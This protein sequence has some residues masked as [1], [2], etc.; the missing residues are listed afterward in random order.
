M[1]LRL[2][3]AL[4]DRHAT[5]AML[6][7]TAVAR[8]VVEFSATKGWNVNPGGLWRIDAKRHFQ[9]AV[10][11][12]LFV[13]K[14]GARTR[15]DKEWPVYDSLEAMHPVSKMAVVDG[16]VI[17]DAD[18]L[19]RTARLAGTCDPEWRS[20]MKHDCARVMELEREDGEWRNGLGESVCVEEELVFPLL[21]S[22]D[23]ANGVTRRSRAVIVPQHALGE[24]TA[25]LAERAPKAWRYLTS[26]SDLMSAR[27]SSIYRGQPEFAIFG[28]GPYSFA[29]WKVAI[30]GLY[31]RCE[32]ALIGPHRDRPA[33]LDDTCYFLPFD[34]ESRA[35]RAWEG[36]QSP[37]AKDFFSGRI[38]WDAKR[39]ISKAI[40]Q[41]L[42]LHA[43]LLEL[44]LETSPRK[45][46]QT[47]LAFPA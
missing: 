6:C 24:D 16:V 4:Q 5:L 23:V 35:R 44:K 38:F 47:R 33:M 46:Q 1:I 45:G 9:A 40:L 34:A 13:C 32:F 20:G 41:K 42:D 25:G 26:H 8:R 21:K 2:L 27:K 39:P 10:D 37:L 22:S 19:A 7:K 28:V 29:P 15:K 18:S 36:L 43:L 30:S 12:V 3:A 17:A 31:K 14:T 11:A